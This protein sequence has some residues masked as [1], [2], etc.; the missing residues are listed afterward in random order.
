MD[1][2]GTKD[3]AG[4]GFCH[5]PSSAGMHEIDCVTWA[6]E[7]GGGGAKLLT[8]ALESTTRFHQSLIA[9]KDISVLST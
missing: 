5:I 2:H 8:L 7:V 9:A 4:Y 3:L 1:E 6:P